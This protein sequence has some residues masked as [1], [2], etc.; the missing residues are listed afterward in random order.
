MKYIV[1]SKTVTLVNSQD[2]VQGEM[3]IF[4]AHKSPFYLHRASSVWLF[5]DKKVLL[6]KRSKYKPIGAQCWGNGI[7]ANVRPDESYEGCAHRRLLGEL[8]IK[9][10]KL[11]I[12]LKKA[13][14]FEYKAYGNERFSEHELDQVFIAEYDG[15][16]TP[17][18][19]E[20]SEVI[21]VDWQ[22]LKSKIT[23]QREKI[24]NAEESLKY[25]HKELK[26]LAPPIKIKIN[27]RDIVLAPWTVIMIIDPRLQT[28]LEI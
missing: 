17:N 1:G 12:N 21:W 7:C 19:D 24:L 15:Q 27:D 11:K 2:E 18:P 20:V 28:A 26:N 23:N 5:K 3:D 22:E 14:K 6:Q 10:S 16:I 8:K 9:D 4:K 13:Y 25:S